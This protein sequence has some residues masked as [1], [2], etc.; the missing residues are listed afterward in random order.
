MRK[1]WQASE[2]RNRE[3]ESQLQMHEMERNVL[4]RKVNELK[5]D[6]EIHYE[7]RMQAEMERDKL[8]K[9]IETFKSI[10][11]GTCLADLPPQSPT[12][13]PGKPRKHR[14]RSSIPYHDE[15]GSLI[16]DY[17]LDDDLESPQKHRR[18]RT[19]YLNTNID[20]MKDRMSMSMDHGHMTTDQ[21]KRIRTRS[22]T[23]PKGVTT[24]TRLRLSADGR[25]I[26]LTAQIQTSKSPPSKRREVV[27]QQP[28]QVLS[29]SSSDSEAVQSEAQKVPQNLERRGARVKRSHLFESCIAKINAKPCAHCAKKVKYGKGMFR[30]RE[31][32]VSLHAECKDEFAR[33]CYLAF[34]YPQNGSIGDYVTHAQFPKV[35]AFLNYAVDEIEMRGI[36]KEIGLYRCTG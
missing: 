32:D 17:T 20:S 22:N 18:R 25:P 23:S 1:K 36:G 13:S 16:S 7:K 8:Q 26:E 19:N 3:L 15:T 28:A 30:C 29:T 12:K 14:K 4:Q 10:L 21:Q 9:Q 6:I 2:E 31:C 24:I 5:I 35:P 33:P 27:P 11:S 34:S